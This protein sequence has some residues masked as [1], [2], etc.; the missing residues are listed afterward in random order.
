M[1]ESLI[2]NSRA[3]SRS[4]FDRFSSLG[5]KGRSPLFAFFRPPAGRQ[6]AAGGITLCVLR[7]AYYTIY[8]IRS[9]SDGTTRRLFEDDRRRG[10]RG[11]DYGRALML[12]DALEAAGSIDSLRALRASRFHALKGPM[13]GR[14]AMTVN[15][16][17]RLTFRFRDGNAHGVAIEDYHTG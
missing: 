1:S 4:K 17:W 11:L 13:R 5:D 2:G 14:Y 6:L 16:R 10:F 9:F 15:D 12:L 7:N 3:A 8:V